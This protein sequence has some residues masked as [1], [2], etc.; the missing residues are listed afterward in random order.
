MKRQRQ[1]QHNAQISW[2]IRVKQIDDKDAVGLIDSK[3]DT[4][5]RRTERFQSSRLRRMRL[6]PQVV[7]VDPEV[8]NVKYRILKR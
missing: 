3:K 8:G 4:E 1:Q 6:N 7:H 2:D 5:Y